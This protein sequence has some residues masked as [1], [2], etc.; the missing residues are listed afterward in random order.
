MRRG[1]GSICLRPKQEN[2]PAAEIFEVNFWSNLSLLCEPSFRIG[3]ALG[4]QSRCPP[5]AACEGEQ[6]RSENAS[7][8][9][10]YSR[11]NTNRGSDQVQL[12]EVALAKSRDAFASACGAL[13]AINEEICPVEQLRR[14]IREVGFPVSRGLGGLFVEFSG[15]WVRTSKGDRAR[16][17]TAIFGR[18]GKVR[19]KCRGGP[20]CLFGPG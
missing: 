7:L 18:I 12:L 20:G 15:N 8:W 1:R 6:Q 9:C 2:Q 14:L 17:E 5:L 19:R 11:A 3:V 4:S 16:L 10:T 13:R